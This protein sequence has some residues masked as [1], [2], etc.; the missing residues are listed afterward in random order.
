MPLQVFFA[1]LMLADMNKELKGLRLAA[2]ESL[3]GV[4]RFNGVDN[5]VVSF[6]GCGSWFWGLM[7]LVIVVENLD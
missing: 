1:Q 7:K 3:P 6:N 5:G 4:E 2:Q